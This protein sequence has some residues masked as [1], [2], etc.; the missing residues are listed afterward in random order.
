MINN[1]VVRAFTEKN[2]LKVLLDGVF[3]KSEFELALYLAK[4]EIRK[5]KPG[6]EVLIDI[7]NM[8][9]AQYENE[10]FF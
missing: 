6:F 3:M 2:Q 10:W 9:S 4:K 1:F 8:H 7:K 5:L